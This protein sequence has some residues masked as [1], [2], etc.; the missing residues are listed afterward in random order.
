M[1]LILL[2][3]RAT[4]QSLLS[5]SD[6]RL[7]SAADLRKVAILSQRDVTMHLPAHI[8]TSRITYRICQNNR[9]VN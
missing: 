5:G 7:K 6:N 9:P 1:R 8:G 4:L 3:H 2:I